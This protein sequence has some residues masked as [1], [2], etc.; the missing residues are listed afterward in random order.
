MTLIRRKFL[1]NEFYNE[2][3]RSKFTEKF[4]KNFKFHKERIRRNQKKK[5]QLKFISK[6][7]KISTP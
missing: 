4:V 1:G 5:I 3:R 2:A 7:E 6:N